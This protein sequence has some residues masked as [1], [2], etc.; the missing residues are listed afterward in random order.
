MNKGETLFITT[1]AVM[2]VLCFALLLL[3]IGV[4]VIDAVSK[5]V[6]TWF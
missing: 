4:N 6:V 3:F 1:M 2:G 5:I